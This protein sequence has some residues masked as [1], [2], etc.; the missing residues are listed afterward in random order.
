MSSIGKCASKARSV[1]GLLSP[2]G[3]LSRPSGP[4]SLRERARV[5]AKDERRSRPAPHPNPLPFGSEPEAQPQGRRPEGEGVKTRVRRATVWS[6]SSLLAL[7][8]AFLTGCESSG[9]AQRT[10]QG[11]DYSQYVFA[12]YDEPRGGATSALQ[13][14]FPMNVAVAEVGQLQPSPLL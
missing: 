1:S 7:P 2:L 10:G 5:R 8:L 11:S 14:S 4:L 9:Q 6:L 12:L 3:P 13:P